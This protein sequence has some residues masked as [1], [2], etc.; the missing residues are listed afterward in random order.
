VW[1]VEQLTAARLKLI[2]HTIGKRRLVLCIDE[3]EDVK[4]EK[5]PTTLPSNTLARSDKL[6]MGLFRSMLMPW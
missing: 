5:Q 1:E 6:P 3:T 2:Q 4:K